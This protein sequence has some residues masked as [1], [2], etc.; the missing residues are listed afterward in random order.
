MADGQC[1][2]LRDFPRETLLGVCPSSSKTQEIDD[3]ATLERAKVV[4]VLGR[5]SGNKTHAAR[6][7]GIDR[8][9]LYRL[10]DKYGITTAELVAEENPSVRQRVR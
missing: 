6:I 8:R 1:L 5:E 3:L 4:E 9:K 7:L 10:I 2:R